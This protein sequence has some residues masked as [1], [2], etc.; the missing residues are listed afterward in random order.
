MLLVAARMHLLLAA[1]RMHALLAAG[2]MHLLLQPCPEQGACAITDRLDGFAVFGCRCAYGF[3]GENC[4]A[5]LLG[6]WLRGLAQAALVLSNLALLPS[7]LLCLRLALRH[8]NI[9]GNPSACARCLAGA[10]P[11][12]PGGPARSCSSHACCVLYAARALAYF[13]ACKLQPFLLLLLLHPRGP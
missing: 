4:E 8:L 2:C 13:S 7:F 11:L 1:A 10:P 9:P 5:E 6:P 3:G 12:K